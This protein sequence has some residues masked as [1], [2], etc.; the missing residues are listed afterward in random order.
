LATGFVSSPLN[1]SV[2]GYSY[3]AEGLTLLSSNYG[4]QFLHNGVNGDY[5]GVNGDILALNFTAGAPAAVGG[6][7]FGWDS[8]NPASDVVIVTAYPGATEHSVLTSS[9]TNFFGWIDDSGTPFTS[10]V[11]KPGS[12]GSF[13]AVDDLILG[14]AASPPAPAQVPGPLPV[15]GAA[16]AFSISR[17]LRSRI[18]AARPRT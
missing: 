16:A 10:L 1:R 7:C 6:Y 3:N 11:I 13:P 15:M 17:R 14:Q 9:S 4:S 8:N 5:L 2:P 12:P 18:A